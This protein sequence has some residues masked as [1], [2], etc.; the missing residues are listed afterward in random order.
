MGLVE[1]LYKAKQ[2]RDIDKLLKAFLQKNACRNRDLLR[3]AVIFFLVNSI[4]Q[5]KLARYSTYGN[6]AFNFDG[7]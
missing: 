5:E 1:L 2:S 6:S 7:V 3:M 4:Y